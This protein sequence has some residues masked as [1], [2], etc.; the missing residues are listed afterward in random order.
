MSEQ[1]EAGAHVKCRRSAR[2][3]MRSEVQWRA[4]KVEVSRHRGGDSDGERDKRKCIKSAIATIIIAM[5]PPRPFFCFIP[6]IP[7]LALLSALCSL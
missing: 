2:A 1:S 3:A 4:R 5:A 7:A 6:P